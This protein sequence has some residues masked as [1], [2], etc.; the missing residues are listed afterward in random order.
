MVAPT[1]IDFVPGLDDVA[2]VDR[3]LRRNIQVPVKL[4]SAPYLATVLDW[5]VCGDATL[6]AFTVSL[7]SAVG[8]DGMCFE[9]KKIDASAFFVT[10]DPFGA[11]TIDGALT[12]DLKK[13]YDCVVIRSDGANW[14]K[15]AGIGSQIVLGGAGSLWG[16]TI[17]IDIVNGNDATGVRGDSAFPF[18][19]VAAAIAVALAGDTIFVRPG[20]YTVAAF[21]LPA[22]VAIVG[23][24]GPQSVVFTATV[25]ANTTLINMA[26][27]ARI[28]NVEIRLLSADHFTLTAVRFAGSQSASAQLVDCVVVVDNG[29][30]GGGGSSDLTGLDLGATGNTQHNECVQRVRVFV[31]STGQGTKRGIHAQASGEVAVRDMAVRVEKQG[32]GTASYRG[33]ETT[34][35]STVLILKGGIIDATV[36]GGSASVHDD[37]LQSAGVIQLEDTSL[38]NNDA[39]GLGFISPYSSYEETWFSEGIVNAA[40]R[41][42]FPG[43]AIPSANEIFRAVIRPTLIKAMRVRARVASGGGNSTTWTLRKNGAATGITVTIAGGTTEAT[44]TTVSV[45]FAIGDDI[46]IQQTQT[47]GSAATDIAVCLENY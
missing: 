23:L 47:G 17:F 14:K 46:S 20:V 30:A 28:Q 7:P 15:I 41:F 19:T 44:I 37:I 6:G 12:V 11:Q 31:R 22:D 21:A 29:S 33:A 24:G 8:L 45:A 1:T 10:V 3:I 39:G 36:Q 40:A 27:D 2:S 16:N 13:Q 26:N 4:V 9:F 43:T 38:V 18:L 42:L 25:A 32:G 5:N 34:A 35:A